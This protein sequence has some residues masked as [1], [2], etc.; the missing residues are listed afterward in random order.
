MK[1]ELNT[2]YNFDVKDVIN[3][4]DSLKFEVEVGGSFFPVKA[5][6]EQLEEGLPKSV[7]C[8]IML[9]KNKNAYLVQNEA[10]LYPKIYKTNHRYI[11]EVADIRDDYVVLQ[12][13]HGLF[14][15][16]KKNGDKFS[17]NEIIVR[18]VEIVK[19][20]DYKAHLNFF[21]SESKPQDM[22]KEVKTVDI[23][24]I[25]Q[26]PIYTPTV[27]EEDQE[28]PS[29]GTSASSNNQESQTSAMSSVEKSANSNK[30]ISMESLFES[31]DWAALRAYLDKN[32]SGANI[33]KILPNVVQIIGSRSNPIDY[34]DSVHFL[35]E[36][37]AHTFLGTI[38]KADIS[39]VMDVSNGIS[40]VNL[41]DIVSKAF[42]VT[43]KLK[44]SLEI[45][46]PCSAY[47]TTEQKNY[48]L[49]KCA[50]L[51]TPDAFYNL[52]K[53]LCLSPDNAVHYLLSLSDNIA[54]AYTLYKFYSDGKNGNR[55]NESAKFEVFRPSKI[56]EYTKIMERSHSFPFI[57]SSNLINSNILLRD[58]CPADLRKAVAT[59]SYQGFFTYVVKKQQQE[60]SNENKRIANS[61]SVGDIINELIL[62][63][64]LDSYYVTRNQKLGIYALLDKRLAAVVP[65]VDT[66]IEGRIARCLSHKGTKVFLVHQKVIPNTFSFPPIFS[67]STILDI[68]FTEK[69]G[70]WV[71]CVKKCCG[72]IDAE[73]ESLP[74][75]FDYKSKYQAKIIRRKDF[76]TYVL[77]IKGTEAEQNSNNIFSQ[78][79]AKFGI[80]KK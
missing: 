3:D 14:H 8:R 75:Y 50:E 52:F 47:L 39:N 66:K 49:S 19:D 48:I 15:T 33:Q 23:P 12:D 46:R 74:K 63:R 57:V 20:N 43:D 68:S 35:I 10:Y 76:F 5:Y 65:A 80:K 28:I 64:E 55:L 22:E 34:W 9:D 21:Y 25:H 70:K 27:F 58:Y 54:A 44:Y 72:L 1:Y 4:N 41:N 56:L 53:V 78:L 69:S 45:I 77:K 32:L 73:F 40:Q 71:P 36:Y 62:I 67:D 51:N 31:K 2:P 42:S 26:Q 16:M 13:K 29:K 6:S 37:N 79:A 24:Q 60:E 38:A 59:N 30:A 61:L 18:C 11:F 7:S 17:L